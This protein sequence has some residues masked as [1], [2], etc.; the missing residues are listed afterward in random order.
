[1]TQIKTKNQ[2]YIKSENR[3]WL[4]GYF[5]LQIVIFAMFTGYVDFSL[6]DA[7]Q[8]IAKIK[9]PQGFVPMAV[10]I[11]IIVMEGLFTNT[12]KEI[13][14]FWR[15]KN[16]LPGHRAFSIIGPR[17]PRIDMEKITSLF[18]NG[19]PTTPKK[20][21]NEWNKLYR[22]YQ[23]TLQVFHSHRAFL[24]TR[25]LASLTVLFIPLSAFGHFLFES[26]PIMLGYNLLILFGLF[27]IISI[28][29]RNYGKR[30]V[31]NVLVEA[32]NQQKLLSK[33]AK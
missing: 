3:K 19:L 6:M 2:R 1:M 22:D 32:L 33:K 16:R 17:D 29:A 11:F 31:A 14:I 20:Q 9:A 13:L 30:F 21:N 12:V 23:N 25:D 24:L 27:V 7:N 8:F 5:T 18:S 28:S 4:I 15:F 26:K 10:A